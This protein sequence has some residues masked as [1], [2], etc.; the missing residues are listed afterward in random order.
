VGGGELHHFAGL[1]R[2]APVLAACLMIFLLSLAGIPPL[3][4]FF[5]KF[6]LFAAAMKNESHTLPFLWLVTFGIAMNCVSL[7]YYLQL[8]KQV[9]VVEAAPDAR[10]L[11]VPF[12]G[13]AVTVILA[14]VVALVGCAPTWLLDHLLAA[15]TEMR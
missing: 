6:Y 8:L 13:Q 3:A 7:Y 4:G 11:A 14:A 2:R 12:L 10:P 9:F 15:I 1:A 5:G